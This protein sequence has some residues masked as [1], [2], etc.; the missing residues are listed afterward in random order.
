MVCP[1]DWSVP[2]GVQSQ[3]SGLAAALVR[4]GAEVTVVT[5]LG[6]ESKRSAAIFDLIAVGKSLSIPVNGSRAPVA[7]T[8]AALARTI[9][10]LKLVRP[11][12]VHIHE[13]LTPGPS[14]AALIAGPR[15]IVATF[16]RS[17][18]DA[19]YRAEGLALRT[20]LGRMD[21]AVAV[22]EAA[23]STAAQVLGPSLASIPV[24][25]NGVDPRRFALVAESPDAE[26]SDTEPPDEEV[27]HGQPGTG[28]P[29]PL[30]IL[31]VGRHEER[32][33]LA[34]LLKAVE[35]LRASDTAEDTVRAARLQI[36]GD[37]PQTLELRSGF[38]TL[39]GT[40][41]LG[42]VDDDAKEQLLRSADVFVAPSLRGESFG[43]VLLEA[44]AAGTPVIASDLP[45][46]RLAAGEA[47]RWVPAGDAA[48]LAGAL[49]DVLAEPAERERL[50]GLGDER[51]AAYSLDSIA[52]R[53]LDVYAGILASRQVS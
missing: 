25:P 21:A 34:V 5:P 11:D 22:S 2:G 38:T 52:R 50:A 8:P 49:A 32:K 39:T 27:R 13:P 7:P 28:E 46:Y 10:A 31:F 47:V 1:Y 6:D 36:V 45:G 26:A 16:H 51:V 3:V 20:L 41:W 17:G 24:I 19:W 18:S 9:R 43:V 48:T 4:A 44:M 23:R 30:S 12:I 15:P 40:E 37:G 35:I 53:Y 33:G 29:A 42:A 14:L